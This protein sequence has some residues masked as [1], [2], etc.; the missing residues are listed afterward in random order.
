MPAEFSEVRRI[1]I[2]GTWVNKV[3]R[4]A[5]VPGHFLATQSAVLIRQPLQHRG[6][7]KRRAGAPGWAE[8][9]RCPCRGQ[10][11][12]CLLSSED[13]R[14]QPLRSPLR[15]AVRLLKLRKPQAV[16]ICA[17]LDLRIQWLLFVG[18]PPFMALLSP[19][20]SY[21]TSITKYCSPT[22]LSFH[23]LPFI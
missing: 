19:W 21:R 10:T 6:G 4:H 15:E 22:S 17:V 13:P 14:Y 5:G 23:S 12:R 1:S 20:G 8:H 16:R 7:E 18:I 9:T 2:L 11:G 3:S